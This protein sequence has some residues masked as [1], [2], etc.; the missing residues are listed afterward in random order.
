ME[1]SLNELVVEV[2]KQQ[3]QAGFALGSISNSKRVFNRLKTLA[4]KINA[5]YFSDE[6]AALFIADSSNRKTGEF[7]RTRFCLHN[8]AIIRLRTVHESGIID[9]TR[10]TNIFPKKETPYFDGLKQCLKTYISFL[11]NEGK[12]SNTIASYRNVAAKFLVFC[13]AN[14]VQAIKDI[15]PCMIPLF[16][17]E[18]SKTWSA[19]SIR[20]S[21]S[22]LRTLLKFANAPESAIKAIPLRCPRKTAI[23][24][25]FTE[26]QKTLLWKH[27]N[28]EGIAP[29]D[30]AIIMLIFITGLRPVDVIN[31][32]L[33]NIGWKNSAIHIVQQKTGNPLTLP[34]APAVGNALMEYVCEHRPAGPYRNVFLK[35]EAPYTPLT[36][37]AIC[38]A[39]ITKALELSG[40][41]T[42][43]GEHGSRLLRRNAA[44]SLLKAG[45]SLSVISACLGHSEQQ[46]TDTYLSTDED[47]MRQ[48]VLKLPLV[49]KMGRD[50]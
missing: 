8:Q 43:E 37:H 14:H 25:S 49:K 39:I 48:C 1:P 6:L 28:N 4:D 18:L 44:T 34:M 42:T 3:G 46:S 30:R 15:E 17:R 9:W 35:S 50:G 40:A 2:L 33:E 19:T 13:E 24:P 47:A 5:R 29:R 21:A 26:N 22:A 27:L 11:I 7:C 36:D 41:K 16:F 32:S 38:H 31:L 12:H 23:L 10:N 45:V 20:T